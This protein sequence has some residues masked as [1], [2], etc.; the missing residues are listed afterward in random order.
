MLKCI[1]GEGKDGQL[2][3]VHVVAS[4][5]RTITLSAVCA[6]V[7]CMFTMVFTLSAG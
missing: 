6:A 4:P 7:A 5:V 2:L 3:T 1:G